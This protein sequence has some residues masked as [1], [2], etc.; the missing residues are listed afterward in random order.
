[1]G[2]DFYESDNIQDGSLGIGR[3]CIIEN[4]ILDTD[5]R[6]GD[7]VHLTNASGITEGLRDGIYIRDGIVVVP[8][9]MHIPSGYRL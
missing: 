6:T 2:A 4:A 7:D 3:N 8:K 5:V 9:G 1:M